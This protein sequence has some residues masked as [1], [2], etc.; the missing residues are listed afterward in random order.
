MGSLAPPTLTPPV[1]SDSQIVSR[2]IVPVHTLR[3]AMVDLSAAE[4][5]AQSIHTGSDDL[6]VCWVHTRLVHAKVVDLHPGRDI[7]PVKQYG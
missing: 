6:K 2:K 4:R 7:P 5:R 3:A 1:T